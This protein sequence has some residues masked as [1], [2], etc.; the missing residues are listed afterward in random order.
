[1]HFHTIRLSEIDKKQN[2]D[3]TSSLF[4]WILRSLFMQDMIEFDH[5]K[6]SLQMKPAYPL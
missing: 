5:G 4:Y 2:E 6:N 3:Y 1:M